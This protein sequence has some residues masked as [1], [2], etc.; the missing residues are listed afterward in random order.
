M[1][2]D[3]QLM[4]LLP[5]RS[6]VSSR[7]ACGWTSTPARSA[8]HARRRWTIHASQQRAATVCSHAFEVGLTAR[9]RAVELATVRALARRRRQRLAAQRVEVREA[10]RTADAHAERYRMPVH[11]MLECARQLAGL[12]TSELWVRY[13]ALGGNLAPGAF[14]R[15]MCGIDELRAVDANVISTALNEEF[16][17]SGFGTPLPARHARRRALSPSARRPTAPPRSG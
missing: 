13:L 8:A 10:L 14:A 12:S 2:N 4:E 17:D 11:R 9:D 15:A 3:H 6:E 7:C 16:R 5:S 1:E